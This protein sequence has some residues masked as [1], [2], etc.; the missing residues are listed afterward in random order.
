VTPRLGRRPT[1]AALVAALLALLLHGVG[2]TP[3]PDPAVAARTCPVGERFDWTCQTARYHELAT[4]AGVSAALAALRRDA[5]ASDA[6][7][8][9]CHHVA[10]HIGHVAAARHRDLVVI[11]ARG[12]PLCGSGYL[13]G[14][15]EALVAATAPDGAEL[16]GLC[17]P[18]RR[19]GP[20]IDRWHCAHALGHGIAA[21]RLQGAGAALRAC[22]R[23]DRWERRPCYGGVFMERIARATA[24]AD[25]G[26]AA[27]R[28]GARGP[29]RPCR[30]LARRYAIE[31]AAKHA[32]LALQARGYDFGAVFD[33][34]RGL[35]AA[36]VGCYRGLGA[37]AAFVST[38]RHATDR[39]RFALAAALCSLGARAALKPC[40]RGA[41]TQ[42]VFDARS[43][44][45]GR[46]FCAV[47][48]RVAR[49]PCLSRV[50]AVQALL[51]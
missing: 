40:V 8:A 14:A 10:H 24:P 13:E 42:F 9:A 37:S 38:A 35:R 22:N 7:R 50:R 36:R 23:L 2:R 43:A 29:L 28:S 41:A 21:R 17:A 5:E 20:G 31:C 33:L 46:T 49:P 12:D 4:S 6:V 34:C 3:P 27:R 44:P 30:R 11:R 47:V 19:S 45:R 18:L 39:G 16:R 1:A 26:R 48:P 51:R 32:F 15:V 25:L